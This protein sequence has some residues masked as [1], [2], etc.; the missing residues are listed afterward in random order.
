MKTSTTLR[1]NRSQQDFPFLSLEEDEYVAL[2]I[3]RSRYGLILIWFAEIVG[4]L[5]L[6]L[7]LILLDSPS[8][9]LAPAGFA[10]PISLFRP[11]IICLY[12]VLILTGLIG[13]KVYL[14]NKLYITNRRAIQISSNA[15]FH[16]S[17]N[18]IEL[19]HIEDVSFTRSGLFDTIF[20]IGTIRMATVGDETTYTFPFVDTPKDEINLITHLVHENKK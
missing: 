3:S 14:S 12:F 13:T 15:L 2:S 10:N 18:I 8:A 11:L 19:S 17:T 16:K 9:S 7:I 4:F 5:A 6:T 1:H 20:H